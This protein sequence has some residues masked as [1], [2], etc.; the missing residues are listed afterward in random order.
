MY[1]MEEKRREEETREKKI[2]SLNTRRY[3]KKTDTNTLVNLLR[4]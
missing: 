3:V 2:N 1:R 4:S